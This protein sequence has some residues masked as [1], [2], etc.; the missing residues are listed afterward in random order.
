MKK[1]SVMIPCID[2]RDIRT[3]W[4]SKYNTKSSSV[5]KLNS[6]AYMPLK[7]IG[8]G[9][10]RTGTRSLKTALEKLGFGKC[11]HMEEVMKNPR[12]LK[13]WADVM[14]GCEPD[15]E[16]MFEGYQSSTDWPVAAYYR[17]LMQVYPEAKFILT[18]RDPERWHKSIMN[19]IY[20]H[21]RKFRGFTRMIPT[22]YQFL[23][24]ME[25]VVWQDI[26]HRKLED[27]ACAIEVFNKHIEEVKRVVPQDHLLIFEA[28]QG[29]EPLCAFLNVPVPKHMPYP[30]K[31]KGKVVR[32]FL[33]YRALLKWGAAVLLFSLAAVLIRA[34]LL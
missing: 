20:Q 29:W 13:R 25:K 11:Y 34:L 1:D 32:E 17:E 21:S 9:F 12:H 6:G 22:V 16:S 33:K 2:D 4:K 15:W 8:A 30:H 23:E 27:Q 19:T 10:G 24:G 14:H 18:V 7:V 3:L 26:F 31:N 28:R 5:K